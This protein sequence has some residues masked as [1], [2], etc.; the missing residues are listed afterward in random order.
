M[1][2]FASNDP[3]AIQE[4]T[5]PE[6]VGETTLDIYNRPEEFYGNNGPAIAVGDASL[7]QADATILVG[8]QVWSSHSPWRIAAGW[9]AIAGVLSMGLLTNLWDWQS[10]LNW[11]VFV[12][13]FL[14]IDPLW[15]SIWRFAWGRDGLLPLNNAQHGSRFWAPYLKSDSPAGRLLGIATGT[16]EPSEEFEKRA[17]DSSNGIPKSEVFEDFAPTLFRVGLPT[18]LL[19]LGIA[20]TLHSSAIWLTGIVIILTVF[21]WL[22]RRTWGNPSTILQIVVTISLPWILAVYLLQDQLSQEQLAFAGFDVRQ[23]Y[24]FCLV[25]LWTLHC[26]GIALA[27]RSAVIAQA[28]SG[29]GLTETTAQ[30]YNAIEPQVVQP[31]YARSGFGVNNFSQWVANFSKQPAAPL[32]ILADVGIIILFLVLREP[33]WLAILAPLWLPTWFAYHQGAPV[34][35]QPIW[36]LAAFLISA[37]AVGQTPLL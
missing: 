22:G 18:V 6:E 12:L 21:G 32:L 25:G 26:L 5:Y 13:A 20:A 8:L 36:R 28:Q 10:L 24:S 7:D 14:L 4:T 23:F 27:R 3:M 17:D 29:D 37:I 19:S 2:D 35:R 9:S 1:A 30:Q 33:L 15:G 31:Q 16:E 34:D 11:Q